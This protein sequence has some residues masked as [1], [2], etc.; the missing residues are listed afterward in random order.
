VPNLGEELPATFAL[1][2]TTATR[3]EFATKPLES[4]NASPD[5]LEQPVKL[6]YARTVALTT[7]CVQTEFA[8]ASMDGE[9]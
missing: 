2:Q 5:L 1:A 4:A 3:T 6:N 8:Y 9:E 7:V